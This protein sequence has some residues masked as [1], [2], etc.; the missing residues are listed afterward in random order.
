MSTKT[1]KRLERTAN[2]LEKCTFFCLNAVAGALQLLVIDAVWGKAKY[3]KRAS[4]PRP[5]VHKTFIVHE[6]APR[7][8]R[9]HDIDIRDL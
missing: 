1:K 3:R 7:M 5:V 6:R 8:Y 4:R 9:V 2:R